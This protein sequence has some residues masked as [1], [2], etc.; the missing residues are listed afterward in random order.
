[1]ASI[2]IG[3]LKFNWKGNYNGS[4]AY[5]VDDVTEYNGS[6]YICILASTGN[7]PTNTTYFQ[8][9]A[10]KGTDGTDVGTTLTTQGDILYRDGSG[11][12]RLAAGTA[13]Q[14]LQTGGSGANPSWT[15]VSSDF[16]KLA[17]HTVSSGVGSVSIDG[18]GSWIDNTVYGGYIFY[19]R[20][21]STSNDS[22]SSVINMRFNFAGSAHT[23]A[24]YYDFSVYA[25]GTSGSPSSGAS[26]NWASDVMGLGYNNMDA[27][28]SRSGYGFVEF[29][30]TGGDENG[31]SGSYFPN[32]TCN[33]FSHHSN[34]SSLYNYR[35]MGYCANNA[36]ITGLTL[37]PTGGNIDLGT[38]TVYGRKK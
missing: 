36:P 23:S 19:I 1:M 21:L 15:A 11:L 16:V 26:R 31:G 7:L 22:G 37:L 35:G 33:F 29:L 13:G 30:N 32:M 18:N 14:V 38:I 10:T 6:S 20:N 9:M 27:E 8:P 28:E 24:N 17:T 4:T 25:S 3:S 5:A 12:Q 2:N 34:S